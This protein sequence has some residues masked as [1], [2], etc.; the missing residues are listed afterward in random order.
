MRLSPPPRPPLS[1]VCTPP[2]PPSLSLSS[3]AASAQQT[4]L[5]GSV[6]KKAE[7]QGKAKEHDLAGTAVPR[8][9]PASDSSA[10]PHPPRGPDPREFAGRVAGSQPALPGAAGGPRRGRQRASGLLPRTCCCSWR[11]PA[12][13][14]TRPPGTDAEAHL[15]HA[16]LTSRQ[17]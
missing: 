15:P 12:L 6:R 9:C 5:A 11:C 10:S 1:P 16:L 2:A 4:W 13:A 7:G 8:P 14:S 3:S 17:W